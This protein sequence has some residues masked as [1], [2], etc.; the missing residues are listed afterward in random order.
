MSAAA[1]TRL[2]G[3]ACAR[4]CGG[5]HVSCSCKPYRS[6]VVEDGAP[7]YTAEVRVA[8]KTVEERLN[9]V[10][11]RVAENARGIEGLCEAVVDLGRRM[12]RGFEAIDRRFEAID[13][14]FEAIDRR[15][16]AV[17]QRFEAMDQRFEAMDQRFEAMDQRFEALERRFDRMEQRVEQRLDRL[18]QQMSRQFFWVVGIQITTVLAMTGA[19]AAIAAAALG[20]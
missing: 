16:E 11:H 18:D 4:A 7:A 2:P 6:G 8:V 15:F 20:N 17:D 12:D 9:L 10:E 1:S 13:Q 3:G 14:R 5:W 19:I